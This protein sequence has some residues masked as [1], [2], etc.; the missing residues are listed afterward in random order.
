LNFFEVFLWPLHDNDPNATLP[1]NREPYPAE[2]VPISQIDLS[3]S[4]GF[5][6]LKEAIKLAFSFW[7]SVHFVL[8]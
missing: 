4:R 8:N 7:G 5:T 2:A 1:A 3:G 6:L